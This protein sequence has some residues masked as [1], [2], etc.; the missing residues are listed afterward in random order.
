[1]EPIREIALELDA[2]VE[3]MGM[4]VVEAQWGG[5]AA[6]PILRLR[7]DFADPLPGAGVT[8]ADCAR[9]SRAIEGWLDE[10]PR[11]PERYVLEVSSPGVD[12]PLRSRKHFLRFVGSEVKVRRAA[13]GGK[14]AKTVQ[15]ILEGV[16][17]READFGI[18]I[19]SKDGTMMSVPENEIAQANLVFRWNDE[20]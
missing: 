9:V 8:V 19:R 15:G 3:A 14:G 18:V 16:E 1:M 6:R 17:E 5:S 10:H 7:V 20:E 13:S 11:M 12:R 4:E 2:R